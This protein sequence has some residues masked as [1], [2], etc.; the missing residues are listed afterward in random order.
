[1]GCQKP[2][3]EEP[4]GGQC[5]KPLVSQKKLF[6]PIVASLKGDEENLLPT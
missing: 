5:L 2:E 1:M 3:F 6:V 4:V